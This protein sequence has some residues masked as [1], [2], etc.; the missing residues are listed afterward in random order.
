MAHNWLFLAASADALKNLF[1]PRA[2]TVPSRTLILSKDSG[3]AACDGMFLI[4][5]PLAVATNL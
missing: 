5:E 3:T 4:C 2:E 1:R